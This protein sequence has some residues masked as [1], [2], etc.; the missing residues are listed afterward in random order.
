LI[1]R[2]FIQT[3]YQHINEGGWANVKTQNTKITPQV[4]A[5]CVVLLDKIFKD[6]EK[7]LKE[8]GLP[9]W[10][11]IGPAGSTTYYKD[12][13]KNHPDKVYGDID[14]I[15]EYP[16]LNLEDIGL[17]GRDTELKI[18]KIYK[19]AFIELLEQKKYKFIDLEASKQASAGDTIHLI[20]SPG[21]DQWIQIDF[22]ITF[23]GQVEWVKGMMTPEKNYK[24]FII[25][26]LYGALAEALVISIGSRGVIAK[27][28]KN[29]LVPS[30]IKKDTKEKIIS[31]NFGEFIMDI[32]KFFAKIYQ[33]DLIIDPLLKKYKGLKIDKVSIEDFCNGIKALANTFEKSGLFGIKMINFLNA[34]DMIDKIRENYIDRINKAIQSSKFNKAQSELAKLAIQKAQKDAEYGISVVNKILK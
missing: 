16:L 5:D 33:K 9:A 14:I 31:L 17:K 13:L 6:S 26:R 19:E 15:V 25:G 22:L 28:Q 1:I 32:A 10:K 27:F 3:Y 21:K 29:V 18:Q 12:D 24:G 7:Q 11:N 23:T 4:V 30:K 20:I 34:K 8:K 2:K